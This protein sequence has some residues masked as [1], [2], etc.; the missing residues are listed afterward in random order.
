MHIFSVEDD[1]SRNQNAANV[2]VVVVWAGA[3]VGLDRVDR[4]KVLKFS[5]VKVAEKSTGFSRHCHF[6]A[7]SW[8]CEWRHFSSSLL[9]Q[10]SSAIFSGLSPFPNSLSAG[11]VLAN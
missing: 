9:D 1:V 4:P 6:I 10:V 2:G 3:Q 8:P 7:Q 5:L 11:M